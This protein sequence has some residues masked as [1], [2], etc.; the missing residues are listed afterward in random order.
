M[1]TPPKLVPLGATARWLRVPAQWL[2]EEAKA[3]RVPCLHAGER[4]L[5]DP[6]SV[7]RVL[8]E[9]AQMKGD[10]SEE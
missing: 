5:F 4:F 1:D 2:E 8:L 7:E 9:R 6:E 3:G 10:D